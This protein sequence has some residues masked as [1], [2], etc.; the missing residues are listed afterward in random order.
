MGG[1][2]EEGR[3]CDHV[4]VLIF[5]L[6][7]AMAPPHPTVLPSARWGFLSVLFTASLHCLRTVLGTWVA[8]QMDAWVDG[9]MGG[10]MDGWMDG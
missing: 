3:G 8:E 7:C 6:L 5:Y 10:W 9:W 4:S 2:G 1:R